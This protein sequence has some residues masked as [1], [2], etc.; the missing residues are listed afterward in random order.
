MPR[1]RKS[2]CLPDKLTLISLEISIIGLQISLRETLGKEKAYN[3]FL[4][5]TEE[6]RDVFSVV[7]PSMFFKKVWDKIKKCPT[8]EIRHRRS[9]GIADGKIGTMEKG[10]RFA[11][12]KSERT[13]TTDMQGLVNI[14]YP[15]IMEVM[16]DYQPSDKILIKN[17]LLLKAV[18]E[19]L[20][21][22]GLENFFSLDIEN[23]CFTP[24]KDFYFFILNKSAKTYI[25][26]KLKNRYSSTE[27]KKQLRRKLKKPKGA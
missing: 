20:Y 3:L 24:N 12:F 7:I 27:L 2:G 10:R 16:A 19:K 21:W 14:L 23:I 6:G 13:F 1:T 8:V 25:F 18:R 5:R 17:L 22:L 26:F 4:D 15:K 11:I 9:G